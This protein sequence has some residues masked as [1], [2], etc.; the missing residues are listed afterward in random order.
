MQNKIHLVL[1]LGWLTLPAA[2]DCGTE[3]IELDSV[4]DVKPTGLDFGISPI[5][6]D[7]VKYVTISNPSGLD[8]KYQASF[9][10]ASDPAYSLLEHPGIVVAGESVDLQVVFRPRLT[11]EVTA[12]LVLTSDS[13]QDPRAEVA[14]IGRGVDLG[15]P[16]LVVEPN[17]IAFGDVG[18][19]DVRRQDV[20]LRN[21][22][23][24]DLVID[25]VTLEEQGDAG[26]FRLVTTAPQGF[27]VRPNEELSLK[28]A[29][30]P[31]E[32][33]AFQAEL[34]I[35]SN[36]P[37]GEL[38][39]PISGQG[40]DV[41]VAVITTLDETDEL[42]PLDTVRILGS[43]SY[44]PTPNVTIDQYE[45]RLA[46]RP[47]GSTAVLHN[48]DDDAAEIVSTDPRVDLVLDLAGRYEVTLY[49]VDSR[50]VR[51]AQ[52]DVLRMRAIPD[53][54]LHIQL[55]WDHPTADLDLHYVTGRSGLFD[56][57]TDCYF[58]NRFPS[59][60]VDNPDFNPRLD[61]D[62]QGGFGPENVNVVEPPAGIKTIY[63]HY[64]NSRTNG[65]PATTALV[66][67]YV[68][69]QIAAEVNHTFSEDE[70]MWSVLEMDWP[71]EIDEQVLL[72]PLGSVEE[73]RRPF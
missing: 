39:V 45:W 41:P 56:H 15:L 30:S 47:L 54:Q 25:D 57:S 13:K 17:P 36:D 6:A 33:G 67:L 29:F 23:V 60:Y 66:R 10:E 12:L 73:Y 35:Q 8:L 19:D 32:L 34:L 28:V 62:D 31:P 44:S 1:I 9:S 43:D 21:L 55:V 14:I 38:K 26:A 64:W 3:V 68:R 58:S 50:G 63:V 27:V 42:E 51:S 71:E 40:H 49:V 72:T 70:R 11:A 18:R 53:E 46:V 69:G 20:L 59:W 37:D 48:D 22:G 16:E 2:C 52:A 4:M 24:R 61:V 65:N 7:T 5:S